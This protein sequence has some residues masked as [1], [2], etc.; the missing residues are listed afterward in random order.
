M[1]VLATMHRV[2]SQAFLGPRVK[3][4]IYESR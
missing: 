3:E 2:G 4:L 1:M